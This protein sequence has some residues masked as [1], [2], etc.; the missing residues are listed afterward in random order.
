MPSCR[1]A[2]GDASTQYKVAGANGCQKTS[3]R[4]KTPAEAA[5]EPG[6]GPRKDKDGAPFSVPTQLI[7]IALVAVLV[8]PEIAFAGLLL[9]RYAHSERV[10]YELESVDVARAASTALDRYLNGLQTTLQTLSTSAFLAAGV[11]KDF[12]SK[13]NG[14]RALSA[15]T[16]G[17]VGPT[18]AA[19]QYVSAVG[20]STPPTPLAV[21]AQ[22]IATGKP[23]VSDVFTGIV[24]NRPL[25]AII[26][27]VNVGGEL[28]YL[29]HISSETNR[30]HDVV[31]S[32][33]PDNWLIGIGDRRGTYVTRSENHSEF[34]GK[35]GVPAFLAR[36]S[37]FEGTTDS[38]RALADA[39]R[40]LFWR[41]MLA[42]PS[43][44]ESGLDRKAVTSTGASHERKSRSHH[45]HRV[46]NGEQHSAA[47]SRWRS[48]VNIACC[49]V[50]L[51]TSPR[52]PVVVS[53]HHGTEA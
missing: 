24:A 43:L 11:L 1:W 12:T 18:T 45:S 22:V 42:T 15:P 31:V 40:S 33:V 35:P 49:R 29:L 14:S 52:P 48:T 6:E 26:L 17:F 3:A 23:V 21:D 2:K 37:V 38:L 19:P 16:L 50:C 30:L 8:V 13:P 34:T 46:S 53:V 25:V 9:A 41:G 28:K 36:A 39:L 32:V 27:P 5:P 51:P 10:R 20:R 4:S 47:T 7:I 44:V